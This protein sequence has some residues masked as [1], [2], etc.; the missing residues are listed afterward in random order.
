MINP[1]K[2]KTI[3]DALTYCREVAQRY[4]VEMPLKEKESLAS[5][6]LGFSSGDYFSK[7]REAYPIVD[8]IQALAVDLSWSNAASVDDDWEK[9]LGCIN[10]LARQ[11]DSHSQI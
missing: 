8:E 10:D 5:E 6:L 9:V 7:W 3:H 11:I 4:D 2:L 1:W